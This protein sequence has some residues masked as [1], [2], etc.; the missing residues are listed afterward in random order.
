MSASNHNIGNAGEFYVLAQLSQRGIIAGKT[1]DGQTLIDIIATDPV[2]LVTVNIQVKTRG[3]DGDGWLMSAKTKR[4]INHS[5]MCWFSSMAL[6]SYQTSTYFTAMLWVHGS[7][8]IMKI[9]C[10]SPS[11]MARPRKIRP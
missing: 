8:V 2:S 5:G 3:R 9:G 11:V 4:P 10:L 7:N 6:T 1:D